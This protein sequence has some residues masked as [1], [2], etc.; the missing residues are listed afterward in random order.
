MRF[1]SMNPFII[2]FCLWNRVEFFFPF[3]IWLFHFLSLLGL[4]SIFFWKIF[5]VMKFSWI[6]RFSL[7]FDGLMNSLGEHLG[8]LLCYSLQ[9][10]FQIKISALFLL[11][12]WL[13]AK[14]V[15]ETLIFDIYVRGFCRRLTL[16]SLPHDLQKLL[17]IPL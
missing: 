15:L 5:L 2:V 11:L 17:K 3:L 9:S 16:Q 1:D 12:W 4:L 13:S 6:L 7:G 8:Y 14:R 10:S